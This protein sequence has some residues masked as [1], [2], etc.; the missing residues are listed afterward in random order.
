[1]SKKASRS[2]SSWERDQGAGRLGR[3]FGLLGRGSG[4]LRAWFGFEAVEGMAEEPARLRGEGSDGA[5][6]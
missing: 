1:M 6:R 5:E 4:G 2:R 3:W